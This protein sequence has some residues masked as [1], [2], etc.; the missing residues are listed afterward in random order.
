MTY[1]ARHEI[2]RQAQDEFAV[3]RERIARKHGKEQRR[4][5]AE[6]AARG[7]I[8]G[9][10]PALADL[11][12]KHLRQQVLALADAY[13]TVS[14]LFR[15]PCD[16][17]V[18]K[19]LEANARLMAA[20]TVAGILGQCDLIEKRTRKTVSATGHP[21]REIGQAMQS[22]I[23]EGKL[24]LKQQR[25]KFQN[26]EPPAQ[27][28][29]VVSDIKGSETMSDSDETWNKYRAWFEAKL[30]SLEAIA[31]RSLVE[32]RHYT[33]EEQDAVR[34]STSHLRTRFDAIAQ[35]EYRQWLTTHTSYETLSSRLLE[36]RAQTLNTALHLW[37]GGSAVLLKWYTTNCQPDADSALTGHLKRW[38]HRAR[39]A[40]IVHGLSHDRGLALT[41]LVGE[42]DRLGAEEAR[43][44]PPSRER[45][46]VWVH[47]TSHRFSGG[48]SG[49]F[50]ERV[51]GTTMK[52]GRQLRPPA[53]TQPLQ[54][55]LQTL[56]RELVCECYPIDH[57]QIAR[58][59]QDQR[60]RYVFAPESGDSITPDSGLVLNVCE[61]LRW[62]C[63]RLIGLIGA[64][65]DLLRGNG[66]LSALVKSGSP[67]QTR[68]MSDRRPTEG[69]GQPTP[70]RRRDPGL[71]SLKVRVRELREEGLSHEQICSRLGDTARP[72]HAAWRHLTWI[73]AYKRH[74]SAV[75]KWI[76][77]ACR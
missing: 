26:T 13:A 52:V 30:G 59:N 39:T 8:G 4:V 71:Q 40:E 51:R 41:S 44:V 21:H 55:C 66:A 58:L 2:E 63:H 11:G 36:V 5:L 7:N 14:T 50:L 74:T 29:P 28:A 16:V 62:Y 64:P 68:T 42:L 60:G 18:E 57:P 76:S 61:A 12:A 77:D 54:F 48:Y 27:S 20:G 45:L 72:P 15:V 33:V 31:A 73:V 46:Q 35:E 24:R 6:V 3:V 53:G 22:A 38:E 9:Y 1:P 25:I 70:S 47:P 67:G 69:G 10:L 49:D 19:S 56:L 32:P 23:N 37:S 65:D 17:E 43:E 75:T 34:F